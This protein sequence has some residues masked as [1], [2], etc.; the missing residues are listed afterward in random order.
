MTERTLR[1]IAW[2]VWAVSVSIPLMGVIVQ[3][4]GHV[5]GQLAPSGASDVTGGLVVIAIE[6]SIATLGALIV[7]R[8]ARNPIGWTFLAVGFLLGLSN[9]ADAYATHASGSLPGARVT[10]WFANLAEG[11]WAFGIFVFVFLLFPDGHLL[12][13]RWRPAAW[14]AA[15]AIVLLALG[16]AML[17][18]PLRSYPSVRNPLGI[19]ALGP[20]LRTTNK[21]AFVVLLLALVAAAASLV[22]RFRRSRGDERQQL[23]WVASATVLAAILVLSGPI[24]WFVVPSATW[25]WPAAYALAAASFPISIGIAML[26]YR[27]YDIDLIINRTLVYG[28]L[29]IGVVGLYVLVVGYLGNVLQTG[30]NLG[31]SLLATGLVAVLFQPLRERLQRS[32]NRLMYGERD[33]PYAAISRLGQ[34]LEGTLSP[35]AV[36][37]TVVESVARALKLPYVAI[38][39]KEDDGY[40]VAAVTGSPVGEPLALPLIYQQE[41]IGQLLLAQRAPGE[42]FSPA[43]RRLLED[44]TRQAGV[45]AHAVRLTADL[46]RSRERLVTAREEERRRLRR[47]LHDGLGPTLAAQTLKIGSARMLYPRD[48]VTADALLAE[49]ERDMETSLADLRRLVYNLRPPALDELGLVGA[50]RD[51]IAHYQPRKG[52]PDSAGRLSVAFDAPDDLPPLPAAVEVA[53]YRIVQEALTNVVHHAHAHRCRIGLGIV[54]DGERT[55]LEVTVVDDGVGLPAARRAGVGLAS[56]RERAAELGGTCVIEATPAVARRFIVRGPSVGGYPEGGTSVCARLPI[57]ALTP[58]PSSVMEGGT[59]GERE[60]LPERRVARPS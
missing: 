5:T 8:Q 39:L 29:T 48:P 23:K 56:M 55:T 30:N 15:T 31:I 2:T 52:E 24:F 40:V 4:L 12:S 20:L 57:A 19:G 26:K 27:L 14:A 10:A 25:L 36:L 49:L 53:A 18:G 47:D 43:D 42:T 58:P 1:C 37:P 34:R 6:I 45:A 11:P 13:P 28:A 3:V 59:T 50:I 60:L 46:Q 32:V 35:D 54:P 7:S 16:D 21:V 44:L 51:S 22:L 38:R 33:D 9:V 41:V 17:P